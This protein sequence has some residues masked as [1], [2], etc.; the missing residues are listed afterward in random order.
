MLSLSADRSDYGVGESA[1][2][3]W[4]TAD[5]SRCVA[6]GSWSGARPLS[7]SFRTPAFSG[8]G[9]A[10]YSLL[11]TGADGSSVQRAIRISV[12]EA[13]L[14]LDRFTAPDGTLL[15]GHQP[16]VDAAGHG[17]RVSARRFRDTAGAVDIRNGVLKIRAPNTVASI[18]VERRDAAIQCAW[19]PAATDR[20]MLIGRRSGPGDGLQ[21]L[22]K[23]AQSV[24]EIEAL[25]GDA[26]RLLASAPVTLQP[27][28]WQTIGAEFR[29]GAV[30]ALLNGEVVASWASD[31]SYQGSGTEFGLAELDFTQTF[32]NCVIDTLSSPLQDP[33]PAASDGSVQYTVNVLASGDYL[34]DLQ[35]VTAQGETRHVAVPLTL[36][37][38][39]QA[40]R[41]SATVQSAA[42]DVKVD[43]P[44]VTVEPAAS[45][46]PCS[47]CSNT[48][49][50]PQPVSDQPAP[51]PTV[52]DPTAADQTAPDQTVAVAVQDP[53]TEPTAVLT[54]VSDSVA[55]GEPVQLTW[56]SSDADRCTAAGGWSG[57][58]PAA[59]SEVVGTITGPTSYSLTCDNA[60]G[61]ALAMTTVTMLT[62]TT[63]TWQPPAWNT[64]G[65]ALTDLA[66]YRIYYGSSSGSYPDHVKVA[67]PSATD[68]TLTLAPGEYY[69]VMTAVDADGNESEY[70][71]EVH[72]VLP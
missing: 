12:H 40:I 36:A 22:F 30:R 8:T 32:D 39:K 49:P 20:A 57:I 60:A 53:P 17:W 65:T 1:L 64:D 21:V 27:Q 38:G 37:A 19:R 4:A 11:C 2:L 72:R 5:V 44:L 28:T 48:E 29:D 47:G 68:Q 45:S 41:L 9:T 3:S 34:L 26:A 25:S 46:E 7:G 18:D 42:G 63:L 66:G 67:S 51:D 43:P 70:S 23:T 52:T 14:V 61:T 33:P 50:Q 55:S 56:T 10:T 69:F 31:G 24:V 59:G 54:A 71:N 16:D 15:V 58:K 62:A 6:G 35:L 13:H